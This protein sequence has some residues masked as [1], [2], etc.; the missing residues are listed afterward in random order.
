V[1]EQLRRKLMTAKWI[2]KEEIYPDGT[3]NYNARCILQGFMQIPGVDY[4]ESFASVAS[5]SGIRIIIDIFLYFLHLC[6]RDEWALATFD[7][8]V[9]FLNA[10]KSNPV[11]IEG[12]KRLKELCFLSQEE[13]NNICAELLSL[14]E[15]CR[16]IL[17]HHANGW[18]H[19]QIY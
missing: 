9:A 4:T 1:I 17:S 5:D 2:F 8:E 19:L 6:P 15:L 18:R 14:Q 16:E 11:Y 3:I 10:L 12:P 7:V 13:C